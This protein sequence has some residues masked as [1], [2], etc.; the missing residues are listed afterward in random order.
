MLLPS[1]SVEY[2]VHIQQGSYVIGSLYLILI[3]DLFLLTFLS[4]SEGKWEREAKVNTIIIHHH[5][6]IHRMG[7]IYSTPTRL[8]CDRISLS[9]SNCRPLSSHFPLWFRRKVRERNKGQYY[10]HPSSSH[11]S[12][13]GLN[14]FHTSFL[15]NAKLDKKKLFSRVL[16]LLR[17]LVWFSRGYSN[18]R[19]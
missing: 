15:W 11:H 8:L 7:S 4:D 19:R 1:L 6:I 16:L 13:Y 9:H 14:L 2:I 18:G 3:A 5:H 10:H 17:D 12:S